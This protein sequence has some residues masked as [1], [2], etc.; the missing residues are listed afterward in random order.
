MVFS[1]WEEE[2]KYNLIQQHSDE[3]LHTD[4]L[5]TCLPKTKFCMKLNTDQVRREGPV[6]DLYNLALK[7]EVLEMNHQ[8][9]RRA[10]HFLLHNQQQQ[11]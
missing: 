1:L 10:S 6:D 4:R 11:K 8:L 5:F 9:H 3:A 7:A 2:E